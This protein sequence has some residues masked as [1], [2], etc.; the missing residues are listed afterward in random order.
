MYE[1][2]RLPTKREKE[3]IAQFDEPE[4]NYNLL[5]EGKQGTRNNKDSWDT[6]VILEKYVTGTDKVIGL[7][8]GSIRKR[9]VAID[10]ED[11]RSSE[12]PDAVIYLDK[13]A[14]PVSW[15]VDA[16]WDQIAVEDAVKPETEY[17]NIDRTNWFM[18][19]GHKRE[20]AERYLKPD[21]FDIDRVDEDE[22]AGIRALFVE[23]DLTEDNW[24]EEVWSQPTKLDGKK[25]LIIDEVMNQGGTLAIAT[26]LIKKAIPDAVVTG[27][28]FWDTS[29]SKVS[30][31]NE[32]MIADSVPVWYDATNVFGRGVG[33]ISRAWY[34]KEYKDEPTPDNL[35]KLI[36]HFVLS[37]PHFDVDTYELIEDNRAKRLQ[38]D[39]AFLSYALDSGKVLHRPARGRNSSNYQK[40]YKAQGI[41]PHEAG[42]WSDNA[43]YIRQNHKRN[44][45]Q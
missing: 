38:Q 6:E 37:A 34:E 4:G 42:V 45:N 9:A 26:Q 36:G 28:Y 3:L 22:I 1:I 27:D 21:D 10:Q 11:E 2:T 19:Q 30:V 16:L 20:V 41:T 29:R 8:D 18:S 17:L 5:R 32:D 35:K 23:G 33:D 7:L 43:K 40:V 24:K 39:I 31:H 44:T 13:S 14:R 15:L 12:A 25:I